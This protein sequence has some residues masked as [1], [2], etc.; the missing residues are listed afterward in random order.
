MGAAVGDGGDVELK[1]L[2]SLLV[3]GKVDRPE[4]ELDANFLQVAGPGCDHPRAGLVAVQVLQLKG[5]PARVAQRAV[6]VR[7][8][9]LFE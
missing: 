2:Q 6:A 5:L 7:P 4:V 3:K 8:A 1:L 9:G